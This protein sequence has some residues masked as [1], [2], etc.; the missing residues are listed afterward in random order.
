MKRVDYCEEFEKVPVEFWG[1]APTAY[2]SLVLDRWDFEKEVMTGEWK[3]AARRNYKN[4]EHWEYLMDNKSRLIPWFADGED[5]DPVIAPNS[6]LDQFYFQ[7]EIQNWSFTD[8]AWI[9]KHWKSYTV[10]PRTARQRRDGVKFFSYRIGTELWNHYRKE[11]REKYPEIIPRT[12]QE[13]ASLEVGNTNALMSIGPLSNK[14]SAE[15]ESLKLKIQN[16]TLS[17]EDITDLQNSLKKIS[18]GLSKPKRKLM[19][20]RR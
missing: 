20:R 18:S 16:G 13:K 11:A 6:V 8:G 2:G 14:L 15:A 19:K 10:A 3:Y 7:N 5:F 12:R 1:T 4:K 17:A 9:N